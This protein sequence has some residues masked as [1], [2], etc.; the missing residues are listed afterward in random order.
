MKDLKMESNKKIELLAPAGSFESVRVAINAGADSVYMGGK[1]FGA[2]AFAKSVEEDCIIDSIKLC[3]KYGK[4]F[5]LTLNN[6]IKDSEYKILDEYLC[7]IVKVNPDGF[8]VAD[9][10]LATYLKE[11][12]DI[13]LHSSTQMNITT[14]IAVKNLCR[15]GFKKVIL[16]RELT[17]AEIK[18]IRLENKDVEIECFIHGSMCY[19]YSGCCL[20]SSFLGGN[21]GNRGRCKGACRLS[22]SYKEKTGY[23]L[24]MKDMCSVR[25]IK[26]LIN[27]GIDTIK[28][29][30]RMRSSIYVAGAVGIY[31]EIIDKIYNDVL[32]SDNE[33][34]RYEKILLEVYDKG[35]FTNYYFEKNNMVQIDERKKRYPNREI[36]N[37][38]K[39][40][41]INKNKKIILDIYVSAR[42]NNKLTIVVIYKNKK[43]EF[44]STAKLI[45][46]SINKGT[47]NT[48][49]LKHLLK[50][51]ETDYVFNVKEIYIDKNIF[52][53]ISEINKLRRRITD[54]DFS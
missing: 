21:S 32:I 38:I 27:I 28:I 18:K 1:Y 43:Y 10:G 40:K 48:E 6:L 4:K 22:Y 54:Y 2:R 13:P 42:L 35:G 30:G 39:E 45:S 14:S 16:S 19:S 49:F 53:P 26:D 51:G 24:S 15:L 5:Y 17:L 41:F 9:F 29:E 50:T 37:D 25:F 46:K 3:H 52:I 20:M 34:E 36:I 11:R 44:I 23:L 12:Y 8:I 33:Y 47:T 31:R 7:D